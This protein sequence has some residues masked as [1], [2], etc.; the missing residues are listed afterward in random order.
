MEIQYKTGNSHRRQTNSEYTSLLQL[1]K[2]QDPTPTP[3]SNRQDQLKKFRHN[4]Y[5]QLE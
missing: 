5:D 3:R 1:G 2:F 4:R